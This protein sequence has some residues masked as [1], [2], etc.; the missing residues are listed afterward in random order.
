MKKIIIISL[1]VILLTSCDSFLDLKPIDFPTEETFYDDIKGLEGA[2]IGAYDELQSGDQYSGRFMTLMEIRGDNVTNDNSGASG[3]INYQIEVFTETPANTNLETAWLS[4]YQIIYRTNLILQNVDNVQMTETQKNN[5]VGQASFLRGLAYFNLVRLWGNVPLITK[6]QTV[7]E[8]RENVRADKSKIYEQII[9]DFSNAKKLPTSWPDAERGRA[10]SY[11]AQALLAKVYLYQKSYDKV[12]SELQ[13]LVTAIKENKI[14]GLVPT[15][16]TF[17]ENLK[18]SKDV[19][20][21]V[22]YLKGGVGESVHQNNRYRNNDNGNVI[23]LEQSQFESDLDNRKS[24]LRPTGSGQRPGKF[25]SVATNNETS[26]DFPIIRS[27]EVMLM[28]AEALNEQSSA[29]TTDALNA[30]NA[31]RINAGLPEKNLID[32][33]SKELFRKAVYQER[34]LELALECDRWFDIVRTGQFSSVFSGVDS[35]RQLYP[36]PMS[37]IENV[38]NKEGWQNEGYSI[39]Q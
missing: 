10:T 21:A 7:E 1:A 23:N 17:P 11:A 2:I 3:G 14:I 22:Q 36:V 15:P 28:Y 4:L 8:A 34:R 33:S 29:P 26:G 31:V 18:T 6:T 27:A 39:G 5:I 32:Y 13:P 16:Q 9:L 19:L 12:I 25:N 24:M 35:Y 20:F 37:E 38:N 30:L